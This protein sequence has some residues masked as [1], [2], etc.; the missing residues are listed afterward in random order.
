MIQRLKNGNVGE[1]QVVQSAPRSRVSE[2][3]R[4]YPCSDA[5]CVWGVTAVEPSAH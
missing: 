5:G 3:G 4:T 1:E 2:S